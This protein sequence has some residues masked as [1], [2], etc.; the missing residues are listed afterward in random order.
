MK[1][2]PKTGVPSNGW[3][4]HDHTIRTMLMCLSLMILPV[5]LLAETITGFVTRIGSPTEIE[6]GTTRAV[7]TPQTGCLFEALPEDN[8][9]N[10]STSVSPC[11]LSQMTIGS[12]VKM[13]GKLTKSGEFIAIRLEWGMGYVE[14]C[15]HCILLT[16]HKHAPGAAPGIL[17]HRALAE[18][19]P[20]I[21]R[22]AAGW[23]GK[24]WIDGY[25]MDIDASTRLI[26]SPD[27]TVLHK[28]GVDMLSGN[29]LEPKYHIHTVHELR[30]SRLLSANTWAFYR[31]TYKTNHNPIVSQLILW[32]NQTSIAEKKFLSMYVTQINQPDYK[33][34]TRGS[35]QSRYGQPIHIIPDYHAQQYISRM[36]A[37]LVPQYQR[38]MSTADPSKVNFHFYLVR[39]F[40]YSQ[41]NEFWYVNGEIPQN[42]YKAICG[43]R[44]NA[45][46][47]GSSFTS[48]IANP[49]G[50]VLVP[51]ATVARIKNQAQLSSLLSYAITSILQKQAYR[52]WPIVKPAFAAPPC[53]LASYTLRSE[54]E[55]L[56]RIGIRQMYLAGYDIREAPYAWAVAQGKPVNNP[57]INSKDPD[58]EIPWY[59]AYAF[60]YISQYY[61]DVD[62]SKLKR[63]EKE[64]QQFLQELR[65]A[66]PEAFA[67][68]KA[69]S[70]QTAKV[71]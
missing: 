53:S 6:I 37:M 64:Y 61:K 22:S 10:S 11:N 59:A 54:D 1:I 70:G 4:R 19:N 57:I 56:L 28:L 38:E 14:P 49:D 33:K 46:R 55:Q 51:D 15:K 21:A 43:W 25:P 39:A 27:S 65:K 42:P 62:Y 5:S 58:K 26:S 50:T 31:A 13:M 18:E 34:S 9:T 52:A 8:R 67:P 40:V 16:L 68:Q 7:I 35:I 41:K 47:A 20:D 66:D 2:I 69:V 17:V 36:G 24:W 44:Y 12:R 71:H 48:L 3:L 29:P 30:S 23:S 63:G 32:L 60:N 45:P